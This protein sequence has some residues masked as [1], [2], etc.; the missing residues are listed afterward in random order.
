MAG[1][2]DRIVVTKALLICWRLLAIGESWWNNI[3][4]MWYTDSET[5][6]V[7]LCGDSDDAGYVG[8]LL[9]YTIT[10]NI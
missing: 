8:L 9:Y 7:L 4:G 1:Y 3:V 2:Y 10:E 5:A 6:A